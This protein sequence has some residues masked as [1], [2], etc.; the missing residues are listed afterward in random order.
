MT[1]GQ[2]ATAVVR[3]RSDSLD[4]LN[5]TVDREMVMKPN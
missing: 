5:R 4:Q 3:Y 1:T 2:V